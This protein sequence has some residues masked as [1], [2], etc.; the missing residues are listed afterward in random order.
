MQARLTKQEGPLAHCVT[1]LRT[2]L[3]LKPTTQRSYP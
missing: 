3:D 2:L 1:N